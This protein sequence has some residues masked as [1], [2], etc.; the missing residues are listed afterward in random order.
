VQRETPG[1]LFEG[2]VSLLQ[3]ILARGFL[4]A[5]RQATETSRLR[6]DQFPRVGRIEHVLGIFLGELRELLLQRLQ[7]RLLVRG[8]ISALLTE[9]G[10]SLVAKAAV[11]SRAKP[12][13][14]DAPRR[15]SG[16]TKARR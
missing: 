1:R 7:A 12:P 2:A 15:P 5:L 10:Q 6:D 3:G 8:K 4:R 9:I 11:L 16:A 14:T 13:R